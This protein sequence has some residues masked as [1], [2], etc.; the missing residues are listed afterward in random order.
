MLY[1]DYPV[2]LYNSILAFSP[3]SGVQVL[4]FQTSLVYL[5][6]SLFHLLNMD[7]GFVYLTPLSI[8]AINHDTIMVYLNS[9]NSFWCYI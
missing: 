7:N 9:K 3:I 2:S 6:A 1:S 5:L 8:H 4:P